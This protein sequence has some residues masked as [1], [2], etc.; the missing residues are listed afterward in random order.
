[1]IGHGNGGHPEFC[2][3]CGQFLRADHSIQEGVCRMEMEMDERGRH[4]RMGV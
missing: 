3:P 4:A 1:V 2:G